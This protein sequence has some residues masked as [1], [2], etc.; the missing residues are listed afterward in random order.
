MNGDGEIASMPTC[1]IESLTTR[2]FDVFSQIADTLK[3]NGVDE[4]IE[5]IAASVNAL[6]LRVHH[7][8][9]PWADLGEECRMTS[10]GKSVKLCRNI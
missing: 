6:M 1:D 4:L 5:V 10:H 8:G 2:Q 7:T 3:E 9:I